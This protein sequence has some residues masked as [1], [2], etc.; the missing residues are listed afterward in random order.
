MTSPAP[1]GIVLIADRDD[2]VAVS[3]PE[4]MASIP[5]RRGSPG[6]L[7]SILQETLGARLYVV[8]RLDRPTS[9]VILFARTASVHRALC[10]A[11]QSGGVAKTY[12]AA[13]L[14]HLEDSTIS[15]PLRRFGSG[16]V[17]V[18]D[19]RGKPCTT[20]VKALEH[21]AGFSLVEI[22]P[23]TGRQHQIRA[24]LAAV[25]HPVAGDPAYSEES[26]ASW[27]RLMLHASRI[28]LLSSGGGDVFEAPLPESFTV[29]L[30]RAR[31][32]AL[33]KE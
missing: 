29:P 19:A 1:G 24:H 21:G 5:D 4:G 13:A 28:D 6:D 20:V 11:F 8:H 23:L 9:G 14:G 30:D 16:R 15:L 33:G 18:D 3:K 26:C 25:S 31:T 27:P 7:L 2:M 12:H 32:G 17:W 10:I 22:R